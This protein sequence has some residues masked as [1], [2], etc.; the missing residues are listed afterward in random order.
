MARAPLPF[1]VLLICLASCGK[2][3]IYDD[4]HSLP[5]QWNRDSV[6][7]FKV[8]DLDSLQPYNLFINLRNTN[9]Y[10]YSNIF[11]I[12]QM[13]FPNGKVIEDTLEY[14]MARP[15]GQW[16]GE[17]IGDAKASKLWYKKEV[18][19]P[20]KGEYTFKI[21]QAMRKNGE[22]EGIEKLKGITEVGFHIETPDK[23]KSS[24]RE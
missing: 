24:A 20:E 8:E 6:L 3:R 10:K 2:N 9:D 15:D 16:L 17:G 21:R 12:T 23:T 1:L 4:Y 22:K 13:N 18:H 19:F 14:K 11:L 7:T 5:N